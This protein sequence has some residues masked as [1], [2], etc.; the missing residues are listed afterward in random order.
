MTD[1]PDY[2]AIHAWALYDFSNTIFSMNVI[3]LYFALWVTVDKGGQDI[4]YS[5]ALS[6]SMLAV[7]VS[8][9]IFGAI[10]DQ[11][12]KRV[13]PMTLLTLICV[14]CTA[15]IGML[16][17]L[18]SALALFVVANF[19]YQAAMLFYNSMLPHIARGANPGIVSGYGVAL[20][21]LGSIAGL[22][23]V[24]P[25]VNQG[26]R[27]A[28]FV[29]TAVMF[30]VF[31]LPSFVFIKDPAPNHA[32]RPDIKKA[33]LTLKQ[34][35]SE[36]RTRRTLFHFLLVHFLILD[37]VN[38]AIAF[39]SIYANKV[40]GFNDAQ[41]TSFL[42]TS[43]V[44]AM[45]S[46]YLIGWLVKTKGTV[47]SYWLVLWIWAAALSIAV[48]SPGQTMFWAVGPLAGMGM[49]GVWV[50]SRPLLV[51]LSPAEKIGEFFGLYGLAGRMSSIIGPM[52]WGTIVLLLKNTQT[53]KYRAAIFALLLIT[54]TAVLLFR[55]LARKLGARP[56]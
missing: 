1:K 37:V 8:V 44:A 49:G 20:G 6:V 4:L 35:I 26:G 23:M 43:T 32:V 42:I 39:M 40:I 29:P 7:A 55:P 50:V 52:L 25:F 10:S 21:Y 11:T 9:P 24:K 5:T 45:L 22:L 2:P 3:S 53:L 12:G 56:S 47:W 48:A 17:N 54:L 16:D 38:T 27:S 41:I 36:I 46:A 28:A 13:G 33:F 18:Y 30:L 31:A 19:S 14:A 51:E 34:T 15:G